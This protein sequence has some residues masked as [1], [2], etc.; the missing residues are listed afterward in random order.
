M[1]EEFTQFIQKYEDLAATVDQVFEK[2]RSQYQREVVCKNGCSDCCHALFDL[3][4]IEAIYINMKFREKFQEEPERREEILELANKADRLAYKI[5]KDA[6]KSVVRGR[7]EGEVL[8]DLAAKKIRCPLLE[9]DETCL[10]YQDRPITCRL[11]GIPTAIGGKGHTCGLSGFEK[12]QPYPTVNVDAIHQK[13]I[14][15]S[16]ELTQSIGSRHA[17]LPEVLVPLSMAL[18]TEY[19]EEYL[20][21][22]DP[23]A[24]DAEKKEGREG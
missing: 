4:L 10:L 3:T 6:M 24:D 11:Y 19:D 7:P 2:V 16:A 14:H 18:L 22:R 9:A 15:I 8:E 12:G 13:L 21:V 5:K 20:G 17:R 23:A 1:K